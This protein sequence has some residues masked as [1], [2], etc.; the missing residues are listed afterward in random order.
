MAL[1]QTMSSVT[2]QPVQEN[3]IDVKNYIYNKYKIDSLTLVQN[4]KYY[5]GDIEKYQEIHKKVV[6]RLKAQKAPLDSLKNDKSK[7]GKKNTSKGVIPEI[8]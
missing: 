5:T 2:Q 7:P 3:G 1:L 4:Q 6:E 8:E